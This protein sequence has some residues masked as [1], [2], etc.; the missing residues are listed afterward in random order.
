MKLPHGTN[1]EFFNGKYLGNFNTIVTTKFERF[2]AKIYT[3]E[4]ETIEN[5]KEY[6][7]D[8]EFLASGSMPGEQLE[9]SAFMS[10][11]L[12]PN[13]NKVQLTYKLI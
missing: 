10:A 12:I 3:F 1:P 13:S 2:N 4:F 9:T 11:C 8:V 7:H 6:L 5:A